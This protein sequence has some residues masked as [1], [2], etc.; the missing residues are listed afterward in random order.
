M[1]VPGFSRLDLLTTFTGS[2]VLQVLT[3]AAADVLLCTA[4]LGTA[5]STYYVAT[6]DITSP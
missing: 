1:P 2:T 5:S 4:G 3:G 6:L